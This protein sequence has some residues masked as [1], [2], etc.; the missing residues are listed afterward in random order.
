MRKVSL[1]LFIIVDIPFYCLYRLIYHIAAI[2]MTFQRPKHYYVLFVV[3][4]SGTTICVLFISCSNAVLASIIT[5]YH[6]LLSQV[7]LLNLSDKK[8]A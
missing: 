1:Q 4:L 3:F 7:L 2:T 8:G 5:L 6:C